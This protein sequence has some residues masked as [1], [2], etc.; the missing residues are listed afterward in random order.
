M[1]SKYYSIQRDK[2]SLLLGT[3]IFGEDNGG[4]KFMGRTYNF[5]LN[6]GDLNIYQTILNS[7]KQYFHENNISWWAGD[8]PSGHILSSQIACINHLIPLMHDKNSVLEILNGVSNEFID[9][10]PIPCDKNPA[11]IAL[12]VVS[13]FDYLNEN[14]SS[15]GSNCTSVDAFIY[16][17]HKSGAKWLIPIEWK[18]TEHY[19]TFDKASEDRIHENRGT[20]GKGLE[21]QRRYNNLIDNSSQLKTIENYVGSIYYQEPFYQLMRQTLWAE[22]IIK[23]KHQESLKADDFLH[24]HIIPKENHDL[25]QKKY[26]VSGENME[27][28]WRSCLSN[29]SKYVIIDPKDFLMPISN[30]YPDLFKY[31]SLRYW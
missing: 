1:S 22:E 5:V 25:L 30:K 20:N 8:R 4:G 2:Q 12:E 18:Y 13:D 17:V 29:Q 23:N 10:L 7:T 15:R 21:R 26:K 28:T 14:T 3:N 27:V 24:I 19:A 31:L 9:V 6:N 11:Y 16:A